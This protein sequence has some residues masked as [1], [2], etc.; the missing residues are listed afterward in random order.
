MIFRSDRLKEHMLQL[1]AISVDGKQEVQLTDNL[2]EVNWCPFFHPSGKYIIW[3]SADYSGDPRA[4]NFDL[5]TM[6]LK[7]VEGKLAGGLS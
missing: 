7:A 5:K 2:N 1:Y 4:A 6:E 3:S